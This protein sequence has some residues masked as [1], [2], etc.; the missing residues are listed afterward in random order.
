MRV[1]L[2]FRRETRLVLWITLSFVSY[3]HIYFICQVRRIKDRCNISARYSYPTLPINQFRLRTIL[4]IHPIDQLQFSDVTK[5]TGVE[6]QEKRRSMWKAKWQ[7]SMAFRFKNDVQPYDHGKT[8]FTLPIGGNLS[9][10]FR[11]KTQWRFIIYL[12]PFY[13]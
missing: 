5:I 1:D 6:F 4:N 11:G 7:I 8:I 3:L 12:V 10:N 13:K 9:W 2:C